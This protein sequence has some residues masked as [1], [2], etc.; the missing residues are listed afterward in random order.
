LL[1]ERLAHGDAPN[2]ARLAARGGSAR[3]ATTCPAQTPVAWSSFATGTNPGGHG[4]FDFIRR[5]PGTCLPD[6]SLTRYEQKNAFVPP[7]A[8][9][10][11]GGTPFWQLLSDAGIPSVVLRCPCT[12]PPDA[13]RGRMLAGMGVPDLRGGLGTSTFYTTGDAVAGE[14]EQVVR[15]QAAPDGSFTSQIIGPRNPR[16]GGSFDVPL[17]ISV[18][19]ARGVIQV[20]VDSEPAVIEMTEGE[21]SPWIR[22]RFK[23]GL[24]QS[25]RGMVRLRALRLEPEVELYASP[26]NFDPG[27]PMFPVSAPPGYAAELAVAIGTFY[28]TGMVEDHGALNNGR[29]DEDAYLA[30]CDDV[31]RERERMLHY[32]MDRFDAGFLFCLFDTPDR[33][34][35]MLWRHREPSHPANA[36]SPAQGKYADA[37]DGHYR[38]C[39]AVVGRLLDRIDDETLLIV[40]SDHGFSSFQRGFNV[41][42]WL[43][44]AGL[45]VLKPGCRPGPDAGDMLQAVDWSRTRAYALGIGSVYLNVRGREVHGII[46]P[47]DVVRIS[48]DI[49]AA[50]RGL[51]DP[52]SAAIAVHGAATRRQ[53]YAGPFAEESPDVVLQFGRRYRASWST[54]LGGVAEGV[55]ED[56]HKRWG[57]DHIIDPALVPGILFMN[58][59]F[60]T[61]DPNLVDLA[62][63]ILH[64]FGVPRGA[65]MEGSSLLS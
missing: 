32:E 48:D 25:V 43:H 27:A 58:R 55:F 16:A 1:S 10:R 60:S 44:D 2:F 47:A 28:T 23:T 42:T 56:N 6:L 41:N 14:S 34:Q 45:L 13:L 29:F 24:L 21:W 38:D 40:M 4:I 36:D 63:T 5:D 46:D 17:A 26:V 3:V 54:A 9:N 57:G 7:R 52:A 19:R 37:I 49:A 39:D 53:L 64:A 8:V 62:P 50:I 51:A 35:H 65:Q 22:L 31:M 15:L 20:R 12:F 61:G 33:L 11:R 30:H 59:R 18:Q